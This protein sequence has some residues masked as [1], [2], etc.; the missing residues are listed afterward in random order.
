MKRRA[1]G[2]KQDCSFWSYAK[3]CEEFS[4]ISD[5]INYPL[6]KW[7][8]SNS[9]MIQSTIKNNFITVKFDG[10]NGGVNTEL[11]QKVLLQVS[12]RELYIE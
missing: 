2:A 5:S 3:R 12:V 6:Q 11:R 7:M 10:E 8:I 1:L 9:R 4:K